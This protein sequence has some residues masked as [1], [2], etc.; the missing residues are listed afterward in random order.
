MYNDNS[1]QDYRA[2]DTDRLER[3]LER[4]DVLQNEIGEREGELRWVNDQIKALQ[5]LLN[6]GDDAEPKLELAVAETPLNLVTTAPREVAYQ[7]LKERKGADMHYKPLAD[8]VIKRGGDLPSSDP[9]ALLNTLLT[10][11]KSKR[12]VRPFRRGCYALREDYPNLD[13]SVGER[14]SKLP[15]VE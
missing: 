5:T 7:V 14:Q 1:H 11:D 4:R 6:D 12:F 9:S 2:Q 10:S 3:F 8:E 15:A 13:R